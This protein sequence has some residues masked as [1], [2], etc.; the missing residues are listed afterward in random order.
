MAI[1]THDAEIQLFH[2]LE[3]DII[4]VVLIKKVKHFH[5]ASLP[6]FGLQVLNLYTALF[7]IGIDFI[8]KVP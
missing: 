3:P 2:E 1:I 8:E 5:E 4:R 6:L 7:S